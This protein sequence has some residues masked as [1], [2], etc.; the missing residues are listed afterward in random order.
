[1]SEGNKSKFADPGIGALTDNNDKD[2][3]EED[4]TSHFWGYISCCSI[5]GNK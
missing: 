3:S 1:M 5:G 4:F 2:D